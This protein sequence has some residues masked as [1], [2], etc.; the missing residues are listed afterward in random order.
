LVDARKEGGERRC[1]AG[2]GVEEERTERVGKER[3]SATA[4]ALRARWADVV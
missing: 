4:T 1:T 3:R 2:G